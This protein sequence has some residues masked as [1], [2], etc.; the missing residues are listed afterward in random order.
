MAQKE[1]IESQRDFIESKNI[2]LE[3]AKNIIDEQYTKLREV[4]ES[5]EEKVVDRTRELLRAL[6]ELDY[7]VYK[8]SHD[9]KGPL[10]RLHGL[11]NL[12]LME[13]KEESIRKYLELLQ[14]ESIL[15]NRVIQK[16]S[17]AHQIKNMEIEIEPIHLHELLLVVVEQLKDMHPEANSIKFIIEVDK[18]IVLH[19]D[20]K[21]TKEL[22]A[23]VLENAIVFQSERDQ[24][25]RIHVSVNQ[26]EIITSIFD[27]GVGID[28]KAKPSLFKMFYKG[29]GKSVGLGLGLYIARKITEKLGG[30][31]V[32]KNS[33]QGAT[34]FQIIL[35]AQFSVPQKESALA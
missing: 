1:E 12:A 16:L 3:R 10:A 20:I 17:Y 25:V 13:S 29:S 24:L 32:L 21:L 2:E 8:S 26:D 28:E 33:D 6:E 31:I 23:S 27:N 18:D 7:F 5:L 19:S 34:E 9:I 22:L 14:R 35:P 15:A 30:E 4:N 11:S